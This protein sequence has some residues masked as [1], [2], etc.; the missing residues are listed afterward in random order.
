MKNKITKL[1]ILMLMVALFAMFTTQ[2]V[3]FAEEA[4]PSNGEQ[5]AVLDEDS[6]GNDS[7]NVEASEDEPVDYDEV[8]ANIIKWFAVL[9]GSTAFTVIVGIL[10]PYL[11]NLG[12][13][14]TLRA[15]VSRSKDKEGELSAE[16][17]SLKKALEEF[18]PEIMLEKFSSTVVGKITSAVTQ[19]LKK[20]TDL[21]GK[22]LS[23]TEVLAAQVQQITKAA[24][25]VWGGSV[26]GAA[27]ILSEQPTTEAMEKV[28]KENQY[29]KTLIAEKLEM[30][31]KE[32]QKK[33][34]EAV[35]V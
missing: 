27:K 10:R 31:T 7:D 26:E 35:K 11:K 16:N 19:E 23:N 6:N 24:M 32:L 13:N 1:L 21:D 18:N 20:K 4:E 29:M 25:L 30:Q 28:L 15:L 22:I 2:F 34:D 17:L 5:E 9:F 12:E 33:L 3:V 14:K 8:V